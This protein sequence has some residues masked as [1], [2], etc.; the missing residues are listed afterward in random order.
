MYSN[1][2]SDRVINLKVVAKLKR[3]QKLNTRLQQFTIEPTPGT[4]SAFTSGV[5]RWFGGESRLQT[6]QSL[7]NL[8]TSCIRKTNLTADELHS[9]IKQLYE[10]SIGVDNLIVTYK[11]D[12]T[13]VSGFELVQQKIR[14][15]I[16][17]NG[18]YTPPVEPLVG[19]EILRSSSSTHSLGLIEEE[20]VI[21]SCDDEGEP[22]GTTEGEPEGKPGGEDECTTGGTIKKKENKKEKR[23]KK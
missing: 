22:E 10:T 15:F 9:L 12:I 23:N 5:F 1:I 18:G 14:Y 20:V 16:N 11:D 8:I 4:I 2:D 19:N 7:D 3:G 13:T 6:V 21:S 17:H